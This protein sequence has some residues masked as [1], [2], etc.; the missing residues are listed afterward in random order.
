MTFP[1]P[2]VQ[3]DERSTLKAFLDYYRAL[4]VDKASGLSHEQANTPLAPSTLTLA[5]IVH[6]LA[7]VEQWWFHEFFQGSEPLEPWA[8]VDWEADWDWD[9]HVAPDLDLQVIFDRYADA[10]A[11]SRL[12]AGAAESLDQLSERRDRNDQQRSLR[13]ILVHMIEE[14]ARHAGHADLI[15]ES[16][17]GATGDFRGTEQHPA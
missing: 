9:F 1:S 14:V 10:C 17:D 11:R 7:V 5:G 2:P 3:S 15:R 8:S 13:W 4:I 6:H 12:I 16:I